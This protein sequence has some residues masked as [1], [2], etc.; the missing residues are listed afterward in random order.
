MQVDENIA[1]YITHAIGR[2]G[3]SD[4][5]IASVKRNAIITHRIRK[6]TPT[7][8]FRL[9]DFD[10]SFMDNIKAHNLEHPKKSI[11][12]SQLYKQAGNSIVRKMFMILLE[13]LNLQ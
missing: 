1:G 7:K 6:L 13:K 11:S 10:E 3:S 8:C 2:A 9:M 12:D 5:Y 4:E